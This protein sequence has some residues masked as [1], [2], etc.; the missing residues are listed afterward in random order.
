VPKGTQSGQVFRIADQGL[1]YPG[2][3][4]KGSLL[5]E[6]TVL[7]PKK[8]NAEQ[9]KLLREFA[10]LDDDKPLSKAKKAIKKVG[11]VLGL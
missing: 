6:I 3:N 5:V 4:R 2:Q 1:P 11:S 8:I 7:I 10:R 9:E